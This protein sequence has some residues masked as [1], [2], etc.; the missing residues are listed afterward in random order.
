MNKAIFL[1]RDGVI[2]REDGY[3]SRVEQFIINDGVVDALKYFQQKG[4]LLIVITNQGGVAKGLYHHIDVDKIHGYL[5][6]KLEQAG[7]KLTA[8]YYCPHH[9]V[10]GKCLC[11][12]PDSLMLEKAIAR[13]D[14]DASKSYFIGDHDRDIEAGKKAGVNTIKIDAN[15]SLLK[16]KDLIKQ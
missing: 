3:I 1:D 10:I 5:V 11:R 4:Y 9:P 14:I 6:E 7:I 13:F 8:I 16:I 15:S 12:K 2:N